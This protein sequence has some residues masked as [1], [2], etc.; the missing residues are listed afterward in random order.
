MQHP[1]YYEK[2]ATFWCDILLI[3]INF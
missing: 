3:S 1:L 2:N